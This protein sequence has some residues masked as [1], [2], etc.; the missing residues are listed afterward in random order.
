MFSYRHVYHAGNHADVLK[1]TVL[2]ALL[3]HLQRKDGALTL[4]DTHAGAG[5]YRLD[6]TEART[7]GEAGHGVLRLLQQQSTAAGQMQPA[8]NASKS[9]ARLEWPALLARYRAAVGADQPSGSM[10]VYPGSPLLLAQ[11]LRPQDRLKLFELHPTDSR[12]LSSLVARWPQAAQVSLLRQDGFEG[13]RALLP[14]PSRRALLL[15]DP[16][17][18]IKTDYPRVAHLLAEALQRFATGC[19]LIWYPIIPREAAHTL[20]RRLRTLTQQAGR[21]WLHA[22]LTVRSGRLQRDE[23]GQP[24]PAGLPGS[25]VFVVNP[26]HTLA[27]DLR[28]ALQRMRELLARDAKAHTTLESQAA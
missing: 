5:R 22:T 23:D 2:L 24:L 7:S 14:P 20:P 28:P 9:I 4:I 1:H 26:P 10:R 19:Y 25:G 12:A 13:W 3:E 18:E 21:P 6:S 8:G 15:C 17:Y 27:E 11:R 16:S